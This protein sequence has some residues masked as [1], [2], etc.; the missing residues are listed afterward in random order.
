MPCARRRTLGLIGT[1]L[2]APFLVISAL[3]R[4]LPALSADDSTDPQARQ[5]PFEWRVDIP[6]E[7]YGRIKNTL[8]FSGEE[9]PLSD[10][11][12]RA[13]PLVVV[14]AGTALLPDLANPLLS[15]Y[16]DVRYGGIVIEDHD[17][18][19]DIRND[20]RIRGGVIIFRNKDGVTVHEITQSSTS[21]DL[22]SSL[23][24]LAGLS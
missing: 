15:V 12:D 23:K 16:R 17:G 2:I 11:S 9:R 8:N 20:P 10:P 22:I 5:I 3:Q 4:P 24:D 7:N 21:S 18:H 19:L 14:L 13:A 1:A 6:N